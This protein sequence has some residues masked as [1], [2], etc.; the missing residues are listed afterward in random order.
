MVVYNVVNVGGFYGG[1]LYS[2]HGRNKLIVNEPLEKPPSW[3]VRNF[4][5]ESEIAVLLEAPV[6]VEQVETPPVTQP[7]IVE[8]IESP[9]IVSRILRGIQNAIL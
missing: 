4:D 2:P 3:A 6:P 7:T 9:S 1:V 5:A 8:Q